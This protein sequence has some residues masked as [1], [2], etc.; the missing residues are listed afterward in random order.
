M[1][2]NEAEY[3]QAATRLQQEA[4]RLGEHRQ[5]LQSLGLNEEE[6]TRALDPLRAFH[7]QL[8]E[9]VQSYERLKRGDVGELLNLH[10][11]GHTLVALRIARGLSQRELAGLL[12][13][14][15]SQVSRDERNEYHG[16]TVERAT[17][18]LDAIN[19]R[20]RSAFEQPVRPEMSAGSEAH[21]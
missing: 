20:M 14:H 13:V 15:E 6:T 9:E 1:I 2:R 18:I 16:I 11:L 8:A 5:H 17:K 10:G 7:L 19:V 21:L 3:Q 4:T 12:N